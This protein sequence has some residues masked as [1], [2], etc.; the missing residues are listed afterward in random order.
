MT[1]GKQEAKHIFPSTT[2]CPEPVTAPGRILVLLLTDAIA[3]GALMVWER[4]SNRYCNFCDNQLMPP[5][6]QA[7]GASVW[8][9]LSGSVG[10]GLGC[11]DHSGLHCVT[12]QLPAMN[13][14]K[15]D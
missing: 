5:A 4:C 2:I 7:Q 10:D 3:D 6:G 12:Q 1:L 14:G 15:N 11:L 8:L 13:T 9:W